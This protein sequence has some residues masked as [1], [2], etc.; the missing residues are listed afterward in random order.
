MFEIDP[1]TQ[2]PYENCCV[3][4]DGAILAPGTARVY[5]HDEI[6]MCCEGDTIKVDLNAP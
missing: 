5:E 4:H 1:E 3:G 6:E 2:Q